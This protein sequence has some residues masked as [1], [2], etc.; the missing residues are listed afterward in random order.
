MTVYKFLLFLGLLIT[1]VVFL[2]SFP[3]GIIVTIIAFLHLNG[4]IE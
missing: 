3:P 4:N 1:C 2:F